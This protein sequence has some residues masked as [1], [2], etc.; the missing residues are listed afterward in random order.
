M[1]SIAGCGSVV[2]KC[3]AG[4]YGDVG[5]VVRD[6]DMCVEACWGDRHNMGNI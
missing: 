6:L 1:N 5:E 2:Y 3:W 4:I